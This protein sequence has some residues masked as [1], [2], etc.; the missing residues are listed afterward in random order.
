[1]T[2]TR[3]A[4]PVPAGRPAQDPLDV[5][6]DACSRFAAH[7]VLLSH[8]LGEHDLDDGERERLAA[9]LTVVEGAMTVAT[10]AAAPAGGGC[11]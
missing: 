8:Q 2:T 9:A 1:M 6:V 7:L 3:P 11:D 4:P 10:T 5:V